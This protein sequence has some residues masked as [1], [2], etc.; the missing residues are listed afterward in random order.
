[1]APLKVQSVPRLELVGAKLMTNLVA[2]VQKSIDINAD[3]TF[4]WT[5]SKIN[6][7]QRSSNVSQWN[8]TF[9]VHIIQLT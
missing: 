6:N 8:R 7:I 3:K 1:M 5:D 4:Y 9:Q 2:R